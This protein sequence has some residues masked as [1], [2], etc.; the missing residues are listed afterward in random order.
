GRG[1]GPAGGSGGEGARGRLALG[2]LRG[3]PDGG[4]I[5]YAGEPQLRA[6]GGE[7]GERLADDAAPALEGASIVEPR[8]PI[9][10]DDRTVGARLGGMVGR[11][12]GSA[13]PP[14]RVRARFE[15]SAGQ[16]LGA[17]LPARVPPQLL[18]AAHHYA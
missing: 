18:P 11:R 6:T 12:F 8:Y 4:A 2:R 16:S 9:C 10:N 14:G 17:F 5:R 7:L 3:A 1:A 15:G 13:P